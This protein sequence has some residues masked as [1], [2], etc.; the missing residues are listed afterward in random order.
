MAMVL[1]TLL[2]KYIFQEAQTCSNVGQPGFGGLYAGLF[3]VEACGGSQVSS[4]NEPRV[5]C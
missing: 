2:L 5:F 4:G 3:M 1:K